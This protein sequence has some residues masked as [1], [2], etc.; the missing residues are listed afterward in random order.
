[1]TEPGKIAGWIALPD[2]GINNLAVDYKYG[3]LN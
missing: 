3:K 2:R 1:M